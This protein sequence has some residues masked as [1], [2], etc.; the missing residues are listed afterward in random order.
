TPSLNLARTCTFRCAFST[1]NR[2][3]RRT[4]FLSLQ[5]K[6]RRSSPLL[7]QP[8]PIIDSSR[9]YARQRAASSWPHRPTKR[10]RPP[11]GKIALTYSLAISLPI[12][13]SRPRRKK[14]RSG[15]QPRSVIAPFVKNPFP[16]TGAD[17]HF[18]TDP[19]MRL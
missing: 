12:S 11:L 13:S 14:R 3:M 8:L 10:L 9:S 6:D 5:T 7:I 1:S 19:L 17:E 16:T 15:P 4:S 18:H 2:L